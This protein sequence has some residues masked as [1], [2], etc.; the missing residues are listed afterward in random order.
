MKFIVMMR[1]IV[2]YEYTKMTKY[3][4]PAGRYYIGDICYALEENIYMDFWGTKNNFQDGKYVYKSYNFIVHSTYYG[5]GWYESN[6]DVRYAVDAGNIGMVHEKLFDTKKLKRMT[7]L[8]TH[9]S[10]HTFTGDISFEY[11]NGTFMIDCDADNFHLKIYTKSGPC[12][13]PDFVGDSGDDG[14]TDS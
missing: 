9:Y 14:V 12:D 8:G 7:M 5:D 3:T 2:I 4:L 10:I 1:I 13:E 11:D 6:S